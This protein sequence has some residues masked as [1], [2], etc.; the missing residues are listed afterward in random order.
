MKKL[1]IITLTVLMFVPVFSASASSW[2]CEKGDLMR[3]VLVESEAANTA[4]CS[5]VYG[6]DTENQGSKTLWTAQYDGAYCDEKADGL[7]EKLEGYG[8]SCTAF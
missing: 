1:Q 5:V 7:A 4:P 2:I 8:W 6:K 3:E